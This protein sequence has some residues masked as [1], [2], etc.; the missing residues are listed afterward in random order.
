MRV[1]LISTS[2]SPAFGPLEVERNDFERLLGFER[3]GGGGLHALLL[4]LPHQ[5]YTSTARNKYILPKKILNGTQR[6]G[7]FNPR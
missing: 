7:P 2:T 5:L 3:Y 6:S 1:A 4:R